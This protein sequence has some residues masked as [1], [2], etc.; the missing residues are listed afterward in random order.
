[1][2]CGKS[3]GSGTERFEHG[4][5]SSCRILIRGVGSLRDDIPLLEALP[6]LACGVAQSM[7]EY[8]SKA[9]TA[10]VDWVS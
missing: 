10:G 5:G 7:I 8:S 6:S 9:S 1:M 4:G 3:V 2:F